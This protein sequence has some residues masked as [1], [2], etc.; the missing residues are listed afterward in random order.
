MSHQLRVPVEVVVVI[1]DYVAD[2]IK[3]LQNVAPTCQA[4]LCSGSPVCLNGRTQ[5]A[6][7][8]SFAVAA[9]RLQLRGAM[10]NWIYPESKPT[11]LR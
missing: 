6:R 9:P 3:T 8:A 10:L 2:D 4:P 7:L 5:H 11:V 1:V